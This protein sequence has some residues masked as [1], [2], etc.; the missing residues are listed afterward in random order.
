MKTLIITTMV[1]LNI[2]NRNPSSDRMVQ[3][4]RIGTRLYIL[5]VLISLAILTIHSSL[6]TVT[7]RETILNPTD[8]RYIQ[9]AQVYPNSLTCPCTSISTQYSHFMTIQPYYHQVCSSDFV[10]SLWI[11][12]TT[13]PFVSGVHFSVPDYITLAASQFK[14]LAQ[15]CQQAH[16]TVDDALQVFS[17]TDFIGSQVTP[18]EFFQSQANSIIEDWKSNTINRYL[19]MLQLFRAVVAGNQL[20]DG[21]L[22]IAWDING[23]TGDIQFTVKKYFNCSCS[24]SKTCRLPMS[25]YSWSGSDNEMPDELVHIPHF[26]SDCVGIEGLLAST[27]ECYYNISCMMAIHPHLYGSLII[28]FNFTALNTNLSSANESIESIVNQL[29]V[30][31]W[32]PD[33]SFTSYYQA[34]APSACTFEYNGRNNLLL[35]I[36]LVISVFGGLSLG[37]KLLIMLIL[38]L[39]EKFGNDFSIHAVLQFTKNLFVWRYEKQLISR[40][41][42]ILVIVLLSILSS[43]AAFSPRSITVE[44]RKPSLTVYQDL[45]RSFPTSLSCSCS[46]ISIQYQSFLNVVPHF[47]QVCSSQFVTDKWIAYLYG[48]ETLNSRF[49]SST[50]RLLAAFCRLSEANMYDALAQ[51]NTSN[52]INTDLLSPSLFDKRIRSNID[53]FLSTTSNLFLSALALIRETTAANMLISALSTNWV[54][55]PSPYFMANPSTYTVPVGYGDCNCALSSKCVPVI[56]RHAGRLLSTWS[57]LSINIRMFLWSAMCWF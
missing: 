53:A 26:Y 21:R 23:Y 9:L 41:H 22:N 13:Y 45:T 5:L 32:I 52:I 29:M 46:E 24:F 37:F 33:I 50:S 20:T 48:N 34:C 4:Q 51:L 15:L 12:Y 7:R 10:S 35:V 54:F 11:R 40:L 6:T 16:R 30:S 25:I 44:I 39:I 36:T 2:F 28:P 57:S 43:L 49:A 18:P 55:I 31:R 3:Y 27:L 1:E 47:H 8:S 17:V 42:V 19:R 38:R 14:L 56:R